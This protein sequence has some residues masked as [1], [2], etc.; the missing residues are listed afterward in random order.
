MQ[1]QN[2]LFLLRMIVL[3]EDCWNS[4]LKDLLGNLLESPAVNK[5]TCEVACP[6]CSGEMKGCIMHVHQSGLSIFLS[7]TFIND[8]SSTITP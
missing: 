6:K 1:Q 2:L 8:P 4:Q 7:D 3:S 5:T